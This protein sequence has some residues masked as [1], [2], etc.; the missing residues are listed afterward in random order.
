MHVERGTVTTIVPRAPLQFL[1][2]LGR[3]GVDDG[4][5][6]LEE[7]HEVFVEDPHATASDGAHGQFLVPGY[8]EFTYQQ[9]IERCVQ[10]RCHGKANG[11][12]ATGQRQPQYVRTVGV[13][14]QLLGQLLPCV[15]A[16]AIAH[17]FLL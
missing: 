1:L 3:Y 5:G 17:S 15:R 2:L 10:P 11:D 14:P 4:E 9:D 6:N 12:A 7:V 13:P 8:S 16:V